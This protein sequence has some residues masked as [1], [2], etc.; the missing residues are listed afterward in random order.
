VWG[1]IGWGIFSMIAGFLVD[2][3]SKGQTEKNYAVVFYMALGIIL[4]DFLVCTKLKVKFYYKS[5]LFGGTNLFNPGYPNTSFDEYRQRHGSA[6]LATQNQH[7]PH[8]VHYHWNVH[9]V[10]L[11]F[12]VL[13]RFSDRAFWQ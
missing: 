11:E 8:L 4:I 1:S 6:R 9:W 10:A 5:G 13:V 2:E 7:F 3:T 12:P